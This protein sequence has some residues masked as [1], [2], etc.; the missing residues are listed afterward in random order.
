VPVYLVV[1]AVAAGVVAQG[2]YYPAGRI[3]VTALVAVALAWSL[4]LSRKDLWPLG[5]A[6]AGLALWAVIRAGSVPAA[7]AFAGTVA[8]F[9][10][11][12]AV[13]ARTDAEG[14][15]RCAD[16]VLAVGVF[17]A[18]TAW[19]GVAWRLPR[20]VVLVDG[21]MW[22]GGSTLTYPNAAAA[23]LVPLALLALARRRALVGYLL[24]VGVGAALS[25]A[26]LLALLLGLVTL[27]A[28]RRLMVRP[29]LGAAVAVAGLA[30]SFP[31]G[32]PQRPLWAVAGL[33][34]G[35]AV[36]LGPRWLMLAFPLLLP[37]C[38]SLSPRLSLASAGRSGALR[39]AV[40]MISITGT[41]T[42]RAEFF[43]STVDG[44]GQLARYVHDEYVQILVELGI[45]GGVL[46][47]C[48]LAACVRT[49]VAG[50]RSAQRAGAVAALVALA[51]H[52][53]FDFLWHLPVIVLIGAVCIGL[54]TREKPTI[55]T[56]GEQQ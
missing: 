21:T 56:E 4:P 25:R 31:A 47:L 38:A 10:A 54:A 16:A 37:A 22:R 36:A 6:C 35:A 11:V 50:R 5:A 14:R 42:G 49:V 19:L 23:V 48:V 3:L 52:S 32:A 43:W 2:G 55:P 20:F 13:L 8:C 7:L 44:N 30:P 39:A 18:L 28:L 24:L 33:L 1:A 40:D 12:V 29:L 46:L 53:A 17:V 34:A 15:A 9:V 45:V 26:G 41:G 51:V 27:A